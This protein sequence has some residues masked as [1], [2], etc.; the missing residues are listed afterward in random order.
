MN[1]R[2]LKNL[3]KTLVEEAILNNNVNSATFKKTYKNLYEVLK[4]TLRDPEAQL[5]LGM[6]EKGDSID[7]DFEAL[8]RFLETFSDKTKTFIQNVKADL[9]HDLDNVLDEDDE[10]VQQYVKALQ[11]A[12]NLLKTL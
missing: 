8:V 11:E 2:E 9:Q 1:K 4:P 7:N 10:D 6:V 3:I 12:D 5:W